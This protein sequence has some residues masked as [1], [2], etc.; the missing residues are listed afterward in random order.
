M[1]TNVAKPVKMAIIG[2]SGTYGMGILART[3]EIGVRAGLVTRSPHKFK[4]VKPTT[5]VVEARLDEEEL[6]D[7]RPRRPLPLLCDQNGQSQR[8]YTGATR[9][10]ARRSW[11]PPEGAQPRRV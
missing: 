4:D 5:T 1:S 8:T 6:F 11:V 10:S 9:A 7:L 2:A 3:E